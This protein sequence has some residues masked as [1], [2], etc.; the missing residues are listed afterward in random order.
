MPWEPPCGQRNSAKA[1]Y[2]VR[3]AVELASVPSGAPVTAEALA[4]SQVIPRK[5]LEA[6]LSD[7]RR[8][9]LVVSVRGSAGGYRLGPAVHLQAFGDGVT[10]GAEA[11]VGQR[12][13]GGEA[14]HRALGQEA[15]QPAR[16]LGAD[17]VHRTGVGAGR[18][19]EVDEGG[20]GRVLGEDG[21]QAGEGPGSRQAFEVGLPSGR[22]GQDRHPRRGGLRP[23]ET[24]STRS[25]LVRTV[26]I[27]RTA[28]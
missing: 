13:P 8:A 25:Q 21:Q 11:L 2:A 9:G 20:D 17:D 26:T 16:A 6:I 27:S 23:L 24:A 1:D 7:I 5:F 28:P 22:P 3:E 12:L 10:A 4:T 15:A 18:V 14:D 19:G